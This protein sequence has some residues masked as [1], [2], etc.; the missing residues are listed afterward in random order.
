MYSRAVLET[1][2]TEQFESR[3]TLLGGT[4]RP[5]L[6]HDLGKAVMLTY[7][8]PPAWFTGVDELLS[9]TSDDVVSL[10]LDV[11][12]K[13]VTLQL[14][15]EEVPDYLGDLLIGVLEDF[16]IPVVPNPALA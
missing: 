1:R 5:I 3:L 12:E 10:L 2:V 9:L 16:R 7:S 8:A 13:L 6:D 11:Q 14:A 4:Y 15:D